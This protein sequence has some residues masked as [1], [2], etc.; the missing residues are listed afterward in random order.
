MAKA[1]HSMIRVLDLERSIAFY[2]EAFGLEVADK[3]DFDGFTLAYLRNPEADF[4]VA[5]TLNKGR[6][7]PVH[8]GRPDPEPGQGV[9]PRGQPAGQ[10]LLRL[11]PRRLQDRGAPEAR[12]VPLRLSACR[13]KAERGSISGRPSSLV[14][15]FSCHPRA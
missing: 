5:L 7:A 9:P 15:T 10:V 12:A 2:R 13:S 6:A 8:Q 3:F 11:G 4:E 14:T 1:I